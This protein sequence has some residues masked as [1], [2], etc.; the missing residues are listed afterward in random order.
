[1][2]RKT[3]L[4]IAVSLDGMI[5]KED[6]SIDWLDEFEGEGDNGYSHFRAEHI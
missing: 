5:A 1:M 3:V 4:Y 6:G 2:E